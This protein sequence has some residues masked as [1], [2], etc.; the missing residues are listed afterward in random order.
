MVGSLTLVA[1]DGVVETYPDWK[2]PRQGVC[3]LC[4]ERGPVISCTADKCDVVF[5][6]M[7]ALYAGAQLEVR[8]ADPTCVVHAAVRWTKRIAGRHDARP[9]QVRDVAESIAN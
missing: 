4:N 8:A 6:P 3:D 5:H 7:C 2:P 9:T 1:A